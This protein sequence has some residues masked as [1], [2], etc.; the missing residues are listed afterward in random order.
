MTET[1]IHTFLSQYKNKNIIYVPNPGNA[2]DSLIVYGTLCVFKSLGLT[3]TIGYHKNI[4]NN[5][6]LFY[7][8]GGNLVGLYHD[9]R[10]FLYKNKDNN[11]IVI[12]P[13]TIKNE[14]KILKDLGENVKIFCRERISYNYVLNTVKHKNNVFLSKDMAFYIDVPEKYKNKSSSGICN[15]FRTDVEKTSIK[16]PQN[17]NDLSVTLYRPNCTSN[18]RV[19][20]NIVC[21]IFD[22]LSKYNEINTNR[23]HI[24]ISGLLLNKK[25]NLYPNNYYKNKAIYDF[26]MKNH[27]NILFHL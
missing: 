8:G 14:T 12:L 22:Y 6:I 7:A 13:H 25:V 16:I 20:Y 9:C 10:N 26:T 3:Y 1:N 23:L 27:N 18:P 5:K 2:G 19:I 24:S 17:N 15:C 4:Y 11:E 21:S